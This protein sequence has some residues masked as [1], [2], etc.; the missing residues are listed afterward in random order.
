MQVVENQ[1]FACIIIE[2][3][4][5]PALAKNFPS[6]NYRDGKLCFDFGYFYLKNAQNTEGVF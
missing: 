3:T 2:H 4:A 1:L 6:R 5:I